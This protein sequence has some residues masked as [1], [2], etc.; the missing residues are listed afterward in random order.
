MARASGR[1]ASTGL[2]DKL[3]RATRIYGAPGDS[4]T[5]YRYDALYTTATT[6]PK[7]QVYKSVLNALGWATTSYDSADTIGTYTSAQYSAA[8]LV[9]H[10]RNRRGQWIAFQ[11]DPLGRLTSRRDPIAPA[12]SFQYLDHGRVVIAN[13]SIATD[14]VAA[15]LDGSDT[16]TTVLHGVAYRRVHTKGGGVGADGGHEH[17]G[18]QLQRRAA[19]FRGDLS[20][21]PPLGRDHVDP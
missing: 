1:P 11:Y 5:R 16:V 7:G 15:G 10:A 14:T 2:Y 18:V 3:N 4:A 9:T 8:G 20:R 12:D 17:R 6:D 21:L 19:R 13:N